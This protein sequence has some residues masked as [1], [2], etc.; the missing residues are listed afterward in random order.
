MHTLKRLTNGRN[1]TAEVI[2]Q[3]YV[4]RDQCTPGLIVFEIVDGDGCER[5]AS[6]PFEVQLYAINDKP[7]FWAQLGRLGPTRPVHPEAVALGSSIKKGILLWLSEA[8]EP[9]GLQ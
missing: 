3:I 4:L 9:E 5:L 6:K 2:G 7:P 1:A 8:A